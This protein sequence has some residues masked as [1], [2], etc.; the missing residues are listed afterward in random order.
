MYRDGVNE[1]YVNGT[2]VR[3]KDVLELLSSVGIGATS[4]HIISQGEADRVL[5][6]SPL[7]RREMIEDALGLKLYEYKREESEK[8]LSQTE[9]NL[10][11]A[12]SLRREIAPHLKFLKKQVDR[13]EQ[14]ERVREELRDVYARYCAWEDV[15][16][17]DEREYVEREMAAPEREYARLCEE[18]TRYEQDQQTSD[19]F[20]EEAARRAEC[21]AAER[22][23]HN[24]RVER[25]D[26][27]RSIGRYE[28]R[29]EA[30]PSAKMFSG[31]R[32]CSACG[33]MIQE[34]AKARL[35]HIEE[36]RQRLGAERDEC[37][38]KLAAAVARESALA[39]A[40]EGFRRDAEQ[41]R[42]HLRESEIRI[43]EARAKRSELSARLDVLRSRMATNEE[44]SERLRYECGEAVRLLGDRFETD[45][46]AIEDQREEVAP[47]LHEERRR[48][49]ERLK[50]RLED[51]GGD[52]GEVLKEY[53]EVARRDD[54]LQKEIHD[55]EV[56]S[57]SLRAMIDDL[58]RKLGEDFS[59]GLTLVNQEFSNFFTL[60]FDGG[61]ATLEEIRIEKAA[62]VQHGIEVTVQLPRKKVRG[63]EMLSGGE[64]ALTSIALLFAMSRVNPPPFMV[65]DETDAALDEANSR[66]YGDMLEK[67]AANTQ[68]VL[69]THNRETMSRAGVLYGV[70][71]SSDGCSKL[72]SVKFDDATVYAK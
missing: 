71:M 51:M 58:V 40:V 16:V 70:T 21:A 54:F 11:Q 42:D 50:A 12:E 20:T 48:K 2:Q 62:G 41:S 4:H 32:V 3:L 69:V 22:D 17:R 28:G 30:L 68:L 8:K 47:E 29:I 57:A 64:R 19:A 67:L 38:K 59:R 44:R 65:L 15:L 10:R 35:E 34:D 23:L 25:Q 9:E 39:A 66:R 5:S 14:C 13:L 45:M 1:Y 63:L 37:A 53:E 27:E 18:V 33:Q 60:M 6:A 55:L 72:L 52:S 43:L 31:E 7:E 56:S 24:A 26:F 36:E 61:S 46:R 49:L